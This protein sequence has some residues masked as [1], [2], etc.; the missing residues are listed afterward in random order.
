MNNNQKT[1]SEKSPEACPVR[2]QKINT[3]TKSMHRKR[4]TT[5]HYIRRND[6]RQINSVNKM[7]KQKKT[8]DFLKK[9]PAFQRE[10][11]AFRS[12]S[13]RY[14]TKRFSV[15]HTGIPVCRKRYRSPAR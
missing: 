8:S 11:S 13:A 9:T 14:G 3:K 12:Y 7:P 2:M 5:I 6:F 1:A 4:H 15:P 10:T